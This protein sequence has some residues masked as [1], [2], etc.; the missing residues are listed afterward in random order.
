MIL[1]GIP[2][3]IISTNNEQSYSMMNIN[4][5]NDNDNHTDNN[6]KMKKTL[7]SMKLQSVNSISHDSNRTF[8]K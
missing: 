1:V 5:N 4:D 8:T 6:S 7:P 2:D 3:T